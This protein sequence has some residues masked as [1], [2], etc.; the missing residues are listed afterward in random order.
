MAVTA[1]FKVGRVT[2]LGATFDHATG[3]WDGPGYATE[4]EMTPDY[5][6]DK[7]KD[8]ASATPSG[9]IR[10]VVNNPGAIDQLKVGTSLMITFEEVTE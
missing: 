8:W 4:I 6:G 2:R 3:D 5:A 9:M 1:K 10:L 7:N